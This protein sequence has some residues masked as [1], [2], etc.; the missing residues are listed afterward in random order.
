MPRT[1]DRADTLP[2]LSLHDI[3]TAPAHVPHG[4]VGGALAASPLRCMAPCGSATWVRDT[5]QPQPQPHCSS[6]ALLVLDN[7]E[8]ASIVKGSNVEVCIAVPFH[9]K[10]GG[11]CSGSC[12]SGVSLSRHR[13]PSACGAGAAVWS[14]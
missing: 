3:A 13:H 10:G 6:P 9:G 14:R 1:S 8:G 4:C 5:P 2:A 11:C 12:A 7:G